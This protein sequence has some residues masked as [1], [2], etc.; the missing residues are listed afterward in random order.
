MA[1]RPRRWYAVAGDGKNGRLVDHDHTR[2]LREAVDLSGFWSTSSR[3]RR[4]SHTGVGFD[5]PQDGSLDAEES[6]RR[7]NH[8]PSRTAYLKA[9]G[10]VEWGDSHVQDLAQQ[11]NA[12]RTM[13]QRRAR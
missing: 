3:P 12:N 5:H 7:P 6:R 8:G 10:S 4:V 1:G 9:T 11:S 13:L 2:A